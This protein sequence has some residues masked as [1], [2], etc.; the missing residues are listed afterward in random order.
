MVHQLDYL[1]SNVKIT[2]IHTT[3]QLSKSQILTNYAHKYKTMYYTHHIR[4]EWPF[5]TISRVEA[6]KK[7]P[8]LE[9]VEFCLDV[10]DCACAS[11]CCCT[12][13]IC[14]H[15]FSQKLPKVEV[16]STNGSNFHIWKCASTCVYELKKKH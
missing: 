16:T 4:R 5:C 7:L 2:P 8:D 11:Q 6:D 10:T 1:V 3:N 12:N 15:Q 9:V 14:K 13:T